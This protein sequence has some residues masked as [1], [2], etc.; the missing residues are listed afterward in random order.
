[1]IDKSPAWRQPA[2]WTPHEACWVAWPSAGDLWGE[3]LAPVQRAF[4][5]MCEAIADVDPESGAPRGE[6]LEV[7]VPD[8]LREAE[9]RAALPSAGTRFHRVEFGDIWLR[10]IAPIFVT[11]EGRCAAAVFAFNGWG[12]KYILP[13]DAEVAGRIAGI[14]GLP[15]LRFEWVLEGGAVEVDGEG[16]CLTTR[17]CLQNPNRNPALGVEAVEG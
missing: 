12:R 7:L 14:T 6:R 10:D 13:H 16:T 3:D 2:E 15:V 11:T 8:G 1:M 9:A 17:Q 4:V 5:A